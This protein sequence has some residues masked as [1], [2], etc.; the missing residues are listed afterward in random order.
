LP[1]DYKKTQKELYVPGAKPYIIDVPEMIYIAVDGQGDPN[2]SEEY[3]AAVET[4]YGLSYTIKMSKK[5]STVPEGYFDYV[6][7]PLEGFWSIG[8]GTSAVTDKSGF[9]WTSVIRQPEFV[10]EDVFSLAK[11]KLAKKKRGPDL[12]K[13]YL[14]CFAEGLCAQV[15]HTGPYDSETATVQTLT[16]FIRQSGYK[17]DISDRRRHHEIYL[18]DPRRTAPDKLKTVIRHPVRL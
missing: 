12:A 10:T 13:A 7:P 17:T 5:G 8:G 14:W 18:G 11:E 3:Q 9:H 2:T 6:V 16:E 15:M 1:V 4:L